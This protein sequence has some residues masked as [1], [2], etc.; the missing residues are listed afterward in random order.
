MS[1][2]KRNYQ[3]DLLR[4]LACYLVIHQH[5]SEFF[6][7]GAGGSV[8]R[9]DNTFFIGL[10]T[11]IARMSVPLFVMI[12][13][14]LLLPMKGTTS[15]YFKKRFTRVLYPFVIWCILY[16]FYF[17][18]YR[19][20]TFGQAIVNIFHIPVNYGVEIGHLWYVYMLIGLYIVIPVISPWLSAC[21]K[22]EIQGFLALWGLTTLLPYIHLI[23]P[24][25]LGECYW[26]PTPAFYYFNG[27]I[28]YLLLGYYI[29]KYG[30]LSMPYAI[31]VSIIGYVITASV[32]CL[33]IDMTAAVPELEL[34]WGFC[35]VNVAML[36]YGVFSIFMNISACGESRFGNL[37][38]NVSINSYG[39]YLAHIMVL[40][41]FYRVL[42]PIFDTTL[43][44]VPLIS[45]CTFVCVYIIVRILSKTPYSRYWLG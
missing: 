14:Y 7:I 45:I 37:V 2:I 25:V 30:P 13:G 26:N 22:K 1:N 20:D 12:S 10:M 3:L 28:G 18:I 41:I 43:I 40:N 16:A 17:V 15:D 38:Q 35:T 11:S 21:P 34:S 32:F 29:K 19:G 6:Y 31:T 24:E 4:V 42:S 27:F 36:A 33:R 39:I 44:S 9:G 5:A 8:V 23:Y